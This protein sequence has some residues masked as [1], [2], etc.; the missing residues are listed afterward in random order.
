MSEARKIERDNKLIA[1]LPAE[2]LARL[3][4]HLKRVTLEAEQ[5]LHR[6]DE[7]IEHIYFPE[8]A[9]VS[10][11][12]ILSDGT[13]VEVGVVGREGLVG[14]SPLLEGERAMTQAIVQIAGEAQRINM[15][16]LKEEFKRGGQLQTLLLRYTRTLMSQ[17][18]QTAVC[19]CLHNVDQRLARWLLVARLRDERDELPLTQEF[20]AHMLGTRRAGVSEAASLLQDAGLIT[21]VRGHI[22]LLDFKGLEDV[23]CECY[24]IVRKEFQRAFNEDSGNQ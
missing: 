6:I 10:L 16:V 13:T 14:V 9:L 8:T 3:A 22:T 11:L 5:I 2:D 18:A 17:I 15:R 23:S 21:Y 19:N 12:N 1:A 24:Q 4:P 20:I 7:P